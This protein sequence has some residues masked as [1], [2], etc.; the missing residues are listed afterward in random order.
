MLNQ[1]E[2]NHSQSGDDIHHSIPREQVLS[3]IKEAQ[4]LNARVLRRKSPC[5]CQGMCLGSSRHRRSPWRKDPL[6]Q[7]LKNK[8]KNSQEDE[9]PEQGPRGRN[10]ESRE[11][12]RT[13]CYPLVPSPQVNGPKSGQQIHDRHSSPVLFSPL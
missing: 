6:S 10:L 12:L 9:Q 7:T 8:W 2:M 3:C 4:K 5:C 13:P 11:I 1:D